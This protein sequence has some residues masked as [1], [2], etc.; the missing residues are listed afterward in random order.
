MDNRQKHSASYF[1]IRQLA[2]Q[3]FILW[4]QLGL[5]LVSLGIAFAGIIQY[6]KADNLKPIVGIF[7]RILGNIFVITGFDCTFFSL[8]Q[9]RNKL[10]NPDKIYISA[11]DLPIF[12]GTAVSI[13]G[14]IVFIAMILDWLRFA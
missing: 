7:V 5:I 9:Y 1:K 4:A 10:K 6:I 14:I 12:L 3:T 11:I 8:I 13:S 2:E